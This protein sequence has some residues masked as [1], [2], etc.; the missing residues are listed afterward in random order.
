VPAG[1]KIA[2]PRVF[3]FD[4]NF[5]NPRSSQGS[6]VL[7]RLVGERLSVSVGYIYSE[8]KNLQRRLDRNLFPP[9]I[10]ATGMPIFPKTRPDPTI[11]ALSINES[12][13]RS[14]YDGMVASF[15]HRLAHRFQMQANYT[16]ARNMD[17]DSNEH[18]F[19][20]E[21]ALNPFDVVPEWSYSKNDV[22]HNINVNGLLDIPGGFT[23]GAI[24][25]ART[26]APYTPIIGFDTQ[27]DANDENDRAII[28]GHVVG[29]NSFRQP[30]F[31]DLDVRLMKAFRF[32]NGREIELIAEAFNVTRARNLNFGPDAVSPYG[33]AAQPVATA[34]QPLFA[35]STARF[36]GPRQVQLGMRVVF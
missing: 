4:P 32:G 20:R 19:R 24:L 11:G 10:D 9:T 34:G 21:T 33:T 13:A 1:L 12:T 23:A 14:R 29:R 31:F 26:G 8:T 36:G 5:V 7:E 17:D 6:A 27:N 35:P 3:G 30:S 16:L 2:A 25:F 18:L 22:R 28:G 15:T